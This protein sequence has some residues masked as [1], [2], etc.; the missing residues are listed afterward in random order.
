MFTLEDLGQAVYD[1]ME[2]T[3]ECPFRCGWEP[4]VANFDGHAAECPVTARQ[5][6]KSEAWTLSEAERS[7]GTKIYQRPGETL[8]DMMARVPAGEAH[9]TLYVLP[10][11]YTERL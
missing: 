7:R 8:G 4:N 6:S 11:T 2:R 9:P 3:N 1:Y 5:Q 10:G